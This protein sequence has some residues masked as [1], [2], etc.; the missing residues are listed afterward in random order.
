MDFKYSYELVKD[1]D[2][3]RGVLLLNIMEERFCVVLVEGFFF[4]F[5]VK[6]SN[7]VERV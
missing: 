7:L 1:D 2:I 3:F 5:D 4:V 6:D